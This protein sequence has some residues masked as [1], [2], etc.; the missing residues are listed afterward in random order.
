MH[1]ILAPSSFQMAVMP[2]FVAS[3]PVRL[4]FGDQPVCAA[5]V[6]TSEGSAVSLLLLLLLGE[7]EEEENRRDW[8]ILEAHDLNKCRC[9]I[10]VTV[11]SILARRLS[12]SLKQS[13]SVQDAGRLT[14]EREAIGPSR[15]KVFRRR[16]VDVGNFRETRRSK[17]AGASHLHPLSLPFSLNLSFSLS[18]PTVL[19][20][21]LFRLSTTT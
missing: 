2:F 5:F 4:L 16:F 7:A 15:M 21:E 10:L 17:R 9:D 12:K 1:G 20:F 3:K 19:S 13:D 11:G 8:A 6:P 14:T 18:C